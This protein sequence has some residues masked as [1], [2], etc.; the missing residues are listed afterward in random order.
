M[1]RSISAALIRL[2]SLLALTGS[3]AAPDPAAVRSAQF[4]AYAALMPAE[5]VWISENYCGSNALILTETHP[6]ADEHLSSAYVYTEI[7][8]PD[9]HNLKTWYADDPEHP[10]RSDADI[11]TAAWQSGAAFAVNGDSYAVQGVN[12]V[13]NGHVLNACVSSYDLC[14]LYEDGS[15]QTIPGEKLHSQAAVEAFL[16][17]AWQAWSFG[18]I[19]LNPDGSPVHD[20]S[21]PSV[22]S[23]STRTAAQFMISPVW[24]MNTSHVFIREPPS[25][26]SGRGITLLSASSD[27]GTICRA[28]RSKNCPL[29]SP[30]WAA[31]RPIIWTAEAPLTF[32]STG[33]SAA[34]PARPVSFRISSI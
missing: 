19:L 4:P 13:R 5:S 33:P 32:G 3:L 7:Y 2:L 23:F 11:A 14:V 18:P 1:V 27:I 16:Q 9:V 29:I 34:G 28:S 25:V 24:A 20:F 26:I 15:M 30:F 21:G 8:L 17:N 31:A 22:R 6:R 12:A 10:A